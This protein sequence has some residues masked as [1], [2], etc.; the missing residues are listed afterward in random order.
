MN[1]LSVNK[2]SLLLDL[3]LL[4]FLLP[5]L[6]FGNTVSNNSDDCGRPYLVPD[7]K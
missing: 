6:L 7:F 4:L 3:R 5:Y 2:N 1:K